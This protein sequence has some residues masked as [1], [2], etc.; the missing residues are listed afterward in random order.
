MP[1]IKSWPKY[2]YQLPTYVTDNTLLDILY[3]SS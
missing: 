2:G 1:T 3:V